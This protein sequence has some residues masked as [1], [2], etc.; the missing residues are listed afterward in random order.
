MPIQY[1]TDLKWPKRTRQHPVSIILIWHRPSRAV[2]V[3]VG[4]MATHVIFV[5]AICGFPA[6]SLENGNHADHK[7]CLKQQ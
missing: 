7:C 5:F 3:N 2:S 6:N 1:E 4:S